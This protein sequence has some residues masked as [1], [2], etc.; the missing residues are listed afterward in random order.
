MSGFKKSQLK[1]YDF[2]SN[3]EWLETNGVGG[4]SSGTV[5]GSNTRRYHGVLVAATQPPVGRMVVLSKLEETI[6]T[7]DKRFELSANQYPG[8][9]HPEGLRVSREFQPR[10]YSR[11]LLTR[12]TGSK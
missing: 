10:T 8:A 1:E 12:L 9:I 6:V 2:V 3:L 4:Y 7:K 5:A 11:S